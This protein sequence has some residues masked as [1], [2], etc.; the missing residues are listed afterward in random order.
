MNAIAFAGVT[1]GHGNRQTLVDVSF[2][3]AKGD[4]IGLLGANGAGKT[5]LLKAVL[6]LLAPRRGSIEVDGLPARRGNP[7]I[8][9]VPQI[10]K[11][12]T[13]LNIT[14]HDLL[15]GAVAGTRYGWPFDKVVERRDVARSLELA[16]ASELA[17]RPL[18]ALSGGE[19]QRILI[20]QALLGSPT[21]LLL[22]EPLVSLDPNHQAAVVTLVREIQRELGITVLMSSHELAPLLG[23][24]DGVLYLGQGAAALGSVDRV[25]T[26]ECLTRLYGAPME[27][28]HVGGRIFVFAGGDA[29][30]AG[31]RHAAL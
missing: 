11:A 31:P 9:Y 26:A 4:F 24:I 7:R 15:L 14:G 29:A 6:G 17:R 13:E 27:V 18:A 30:A 2:G 19:R 20:A 10:R 28:A 5:T 3:I 12:L 1:L 8:G 25:I 23:Q 21:M 22:D 16:Q